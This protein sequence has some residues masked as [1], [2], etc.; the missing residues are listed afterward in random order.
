MSARSSVF[1]SFPYNKW[2]IFVKC[3]TADFREHLSTCFNLVKSKKSSHEELRT[4]MIY[5]LL[6]HVKSFPRHRDSKSVV[7]MRRQSACRVKRGKS[8][9]NAGILV[10][11]FQLQEPMIPQLDIKFPAFHG[12]RRFIRNGMTLFAIQR[13]LNPVHAISC[14][15]LKIHCNIILP[16]NSRPF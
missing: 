6:E 7:K 13:R 8:H 9:T 5:L 16:S 15:I 14:Y 1:L 12:I 10:L 4:F 2:L 11:S 3:H